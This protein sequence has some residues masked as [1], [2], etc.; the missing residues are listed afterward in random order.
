MKKSSELG[1]TSASEL[2]KS[3]SILVPNGDGT[4]ADYCKCCKE[5][6]CPLINTSTF[7]FNNSGSTFATI[8]GVFPLDPAL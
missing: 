5:W 1:L 7:Y 2:I 6:S 4:V 3:K 8:S